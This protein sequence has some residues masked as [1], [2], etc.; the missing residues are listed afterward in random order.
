MAETPIA[1]AQRPGPLFVYS[2]AAHTIAL[3]AGAGL[4]PWAAGTV[5]TAWAWLVFALLQP[6]MS[7]ARWALALALALPLGWWACSVTARDLGLRDPRCIVW[8]EVLG[9]WLVLWLLTPASWTEQLAAFAL[10]RFFDA[11]KPGPVAWA[12]S[13]YA[14][15]DPH[16]QRHGWWRIGWGIVLDDLV[17]AFCTLLLLAAWRAL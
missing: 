5:G 10:F 2:H 1:A 7:E 4:S 14:G 6:W 9:F 16:R 13:L 17:A 11:V 3:A 12:D 15:V 8:D